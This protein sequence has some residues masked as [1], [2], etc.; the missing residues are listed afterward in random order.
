MSPR[1]LSNRRIHEVRDALASY[2]PV[3]E[4][5]DIN[6]LSRL[7]QAVL[8]SID[9]RD[10]RDTTTVELIEQLEL[11]LQTIRIRKTGEIKAA[12]RRREDDVVVLESCVDD[13]PF[14][15]SS[16]RALVA[17]EGLEVRTSL[18][19]VTKL[20]R[21]RQGGLVDFNSGSR[22]SI[23]RIEARAPHGYDLSEAGLAGLRD[24]LEQRLRITSAM[25]GD[26]QTMK[27]HVRSLADGYASAAVMSAAELSVDLREAEG[28][29]R[30][31]CEDN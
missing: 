4:G 11:V 9:V 1:E 5:T 17:S 8:S 12:V 15:V 16:V 18:N 3:Y 25:V 2:Q 19:A 22:E 6:Q 31:L 13:Q 21:D 29:L 26:F 7:C 24:R 30:W 27:S 20:R 14:L 10:L 28:L 23:I